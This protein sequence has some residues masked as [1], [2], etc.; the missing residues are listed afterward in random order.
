MKLPHRKDIFPMYAVRKTRPVSAFTMI[1]LLVVIAII[2]VLI[3]LLLPAVQ[4]ARAAA[5]RAQCVNNLKQIGLAVYNFENSYSYIPAAGVGPYND[6]TAYNHGWMTFILPYVEQNTV[7]NSYNMNANWYDLS[8][9]TAVNTAINVYQCPAAVGNHITSGIIDDL[10]YSGGTPISASTSDYTNTGDVDNSLYLAS[11]MAV[12]G[13]GYPQ[14]M[15]TQPNQYP[16]P[17]GGTPGFRLAT[18]T[19]GLS[20]TIAVTECANRPTLY[21]KRGPGTQAVTGSY[22]GTTDNTGLIV[23]GGPWASDLKM[24]GPQGATA[25]GYS[26]PGPCMINCTNEWEVYSMHAGGAN[27]LMGDG[28]VRFLKETIGPSVFAAL[29]TRANGEIISSDSY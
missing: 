8:N 13:A 1:E 16:P 4:S 25:D 9:Q 17:A 15:I 12:P 18:V 22:A 5:R 6:G 26:K 27:M 19:D 20:N 14:G 21:V 3:A 29:I 7:Y 24:L 23:F 11:G 10:F 28:S 2:A